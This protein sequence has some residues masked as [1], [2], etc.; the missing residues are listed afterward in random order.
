MSF[1]QAGFSK[2]IMKLQVDVMGSWWTD[3]LD[4]I[5]TGHSG[6]PSPCC[7]LHRV[8]AHPG[9]PIH[10]PLKP[11]L[12]FLLQLSEKIWGRGKMIFPD[13]EKL[14]QIHLGDKNK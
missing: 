2:H 12:V 3:N 7:G 1:L 10:S 14:L 5:N 8:P 11:A 9:I 6:S 13:R 4:A